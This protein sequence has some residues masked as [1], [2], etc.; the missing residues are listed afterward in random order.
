[1]KTTT[2]NHHITLVAALLL[3]PLTALL[4]AD[5]RLAAVLSD[6][7]VLQREK[8]VPV[9]GW[10]DAGER[11]TVEFAGQKK[12]AIADATGIWR[13]KLDPLQASAESRALIVR[14]EKPERKL[15]V[16]DVLVGEVWLGSGQSNMALRVS[17]ARNYQNEQAAANFPLI[18][19]FNEGSKTA[20]KA[21]A[22]AS[23][24]W[25]ACSPATVGT[26]SATLYFF[27][28]ELQRELNVPVGL[29]NSS[30]GGT[31]I[32]S[33]IAAEVQQPEWKKAATSKPKAPTPRPA[34]NPAAAEAARN[35]QA[36]G[37]FNGKIAPLIPYALRGV[38]WYQ[39]EA[40]TH[41]GKARFYQDQLSLLVSD[42]RKRWSEELP[43]AWVQL[44]NYNRPGQGWSLVREAMLKSLRLPKTG[45]AITV[46]IGDADHIHPK[47]KQDV[48]R[49]LAVWALGTGYDR[50]VPAISGP[51]PAGH[52]IKGNQ[53][54]VTFKHSDGGLVA[55][56]GGL[57]G[58]LVAGKDKAWKPAQATIAGDQ[59]IVSSTEV[60]KPV[61]VRYAWASVAVCNLFNGAGLPA[62]PFRTDAWP[63]D[64]TEKD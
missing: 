42:W 33:W 1:M 55:K 57:T 50:K 13:V 29:I 9:W 35:N 21:Q 43:F 22:D 24:K 56:D 47:N 14:S 25:T 16:A 11:I 3:T 4:A 52:E 53:I 31:P 41:P 61:A 20:A 46:D 37:L 7:M 17:G 5:L 63:V 28:R 32:E 60:A 54:I 10:A 30:V 51:L 19:T 34:E 6:H 12:T 64:D 48:G 45:M 2:M 15:E 40:N 38:L 27:G 23:G 8:P 39:G 26:F 62:S 59:V 49:R 44:P 18:R 58:F 36:G